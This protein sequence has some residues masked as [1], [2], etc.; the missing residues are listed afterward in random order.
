MIH[1]EE[2]E[3]TIV[4]ESTKVEGKIVFDRMTRIHGV[5]VGEVE[6]KKGSTLVLAESGLVEGTVHADTLIVDGTIQGDI[7]VNTRLLVSR[8]G[9]IIGNIHTPSLTLDFGA[10]FEGTCRMPETHSTPEKK[11]V[12]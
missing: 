8:T 7:F 10:F 5:L 9:R 2:S 3:V 6:S 1:F 12:P 11:Q 4:G